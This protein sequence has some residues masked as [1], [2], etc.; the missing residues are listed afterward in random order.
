[1]EH[2]MAT[3][4][5]RSFIVDEVGSLD[6]NASAIFPYNKPNRLEPRFPY[7]IDANAYRCDKKSNYPK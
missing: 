7:T 6:R 3:F 2:I 5:K 4:N 1:M